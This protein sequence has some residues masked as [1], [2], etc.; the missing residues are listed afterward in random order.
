[1]QCFNCELLFRD[2]LI[3]V[4]VNNFEITKICFVILLVFRNTNLRT[5]AA[6][7]NFNVSLRIVV[8]TPC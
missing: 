1:M 8:N 6:R 7:A 4:A 3:N 2:W 5:R